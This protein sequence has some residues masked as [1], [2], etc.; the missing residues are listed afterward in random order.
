MHTTEL[1]QSL[2]A[3]VLGWYDFDKI[4]VPIRTSSDVHIYRMVHTHEQIHQL[5]NQ[6]S[7]FG[8]IVDRLGRLA[9]L[10]T[11][12]ADLLMRQYVTASRT[13]HETAATYLGIVLTGEN[14]LKG[15]LSE[16]YVNYYHI[17]ENMVQSTAESRLWRAVVL[18]QVVHCAF[19]T[20]WDDRIEPSR[21]S[22]ES[23]LEMAADYIRRAENSP[24]QR[25]A[26]LLSASRI[27][28]KDALCQALEHLGMTR[29][30]CEMFARLQSPDTI[31]SRLSLPASDWPQLISGFEEAMKDAVY[32]WAEPHLPGLNSNR[33]ELFN[34]M[35]IRQTAAR[36]MTQMSGLLMLDDSSNHEHSN[37]QQRATNSRLDQSS[38]ERYM[39]AQKRGS[40]FVNAFIEHMNTRSDLVPQVD[41]RITSGRMMSITEFV[42][43]TTNERHDDHDLLFHLRRVAN[44]RLLTGVHERLE[45]ERCDSLIVPT[46]HVAHFFAL[47][48]DDSS[49]GCSTHGLWRV[50]RQSQD[51][52]QAS[53]E[54]LPMTNH[55]HGFI[56]ICENRHRNGQWSSFRRHYQEWSGEML[57]LIEDNLIDFCEAVVRSGTAAK[58]WCQSVTVEKSV[59]IW[60]LLFFLEGWQHPFVSFCNQAVYDAI[61]CFV[62]EYLDD[63]AKLREIHDAQVRELVGTLTLSMLKEHPCLDVYCHGRVVRD[64]LA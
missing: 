13:A 49:E 18:A 48:V 61:R 51:R 23:F 30:I 33:H 28:N 35:L 7:T 50:H 64:Y 31:L 24:D 38:L 36:L 27:L 29:S 43:V 21:S 46:G 53:R 54:S 56:C 9:R 2:E 45:I 44:Q 39:P 25:L 42:G 41:M 57:L 11:P 17:A 10:H 4:N 40:P 15:L 63:S 62:N 12:N 52:I 20:E 6:S 3:L 8:F 55:D 22:D 47:I 16:T 37:D 34:A 32:A 60:I 14:D 59:S 1:F 26:I 19:V 5:I 58:W